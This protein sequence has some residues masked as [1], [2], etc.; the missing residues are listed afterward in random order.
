MRQVAT[1][2][3]KVHALT[4]REWDVLA[5]LAEGRTTRDIAAALRVSP[6]TISAHLRHIFA[7]LGVHT[8]VAAVHAGYALLVRGDPWLDWRD[9]RRVGGDW[10]PSPPN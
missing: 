5:A 7:K 10:P 6:K 4:Q 9:Y 2:K 3:A 1:A 8:R